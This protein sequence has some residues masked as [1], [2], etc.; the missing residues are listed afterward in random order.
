MKVFNIKAIINKKNGQI[1]FSLPK[2]KLSE[3]LKKNILETKRIKINIIEDI[4]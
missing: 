2:K 4:K 1:N 3:T